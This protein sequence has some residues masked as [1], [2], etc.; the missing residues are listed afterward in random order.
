MIDN[1]RVSELRKRLEPRKRK[2][3][4][5][6]PEVHDKWDIWDNRRNDWLNEGISGPFWFRKQAE[7]ACDKL[8]EYYGHMHLTEN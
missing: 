3:F 4:P 1:E 6:F 2:D 7:R 5:R 8:S